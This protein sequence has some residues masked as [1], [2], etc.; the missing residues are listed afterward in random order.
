MKVASVNCPFK[1]DQIE[2]IVPIYVAIAGMLYID[3]GITAL[4]VL[5]FEFAIKQKI[6]QYHKWGNY[7]SR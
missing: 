1:Y 2:A 5:V 3:L 7:I 4:L 6:P